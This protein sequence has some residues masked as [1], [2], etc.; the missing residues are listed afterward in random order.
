MREVVDV[1]SD[2]EVGVEGE[3]ELMEES[4]VAAVAGVMVV[5]R[6]TVRPAVMTE[7]AVWVAA[8]RQLQ[9]VR[10]AGC[11]LVAVSVGCAC[12]SWD[13]CGRCMAVQ[14]VPHPAGRRADGGWNQRC[15]T[16]GYCHLASTGSASTRHTPVLDSERGAAQT[17]MYTLVHHAAHMMRQCQHH[18]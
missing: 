4:A 14:P 6:T 10:R 11:G 17:W 13:R 2:V 15:T 5:V 9:R 18:Q 3:V 16:I 8:H 12:S 1:D 7:A